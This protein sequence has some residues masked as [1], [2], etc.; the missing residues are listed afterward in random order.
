MLTLTRRLGERIVIGDTV[1]IEVVQIQG[2]RVRLGIR[3]PRSLPVYRGE[4][5]DRIKGEN[6]KARGG[7]DVVPW[8]L[9]P[10][11]PV[12]KFPRGIFG[13]PELTEWVLCELTDGADIAGDSDTV[14]RVIVAVADPAIRLLVVDLCSL[15]NS[16][17][18][19]LACAAAGFSSADVA[20]AGVVTAPADGTAPTVNTMAPVVIDMA[21]LEAVQ[22]ILTDDTLS[23]THPLGASPPRKVAS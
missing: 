15:D 2:G 8:R 4:L 14:V 3:A 20:I 10:G 21:T 6:L 18:V 11:T 13:M 19:E 23:V 5:V 1:E 16:Y 9:E 17:P 7:G 22:V 12:I